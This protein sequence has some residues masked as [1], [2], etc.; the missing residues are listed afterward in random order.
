[1]GVLC[2]C[3]SIPRAEL[4]Q[5]FR[6][7]DDSRAK[8]SIRFVWQEGRSAIPFLIDCLRDKDPNVRLMALR[9]LMGIGREARSAAP[10]VLA[11]LHD[12]AKRVREHAITAAA[13]IA[14]DEPDTLR[15]LT[16]ILEQV[17]ISSES[18][19]GPWHVCLALKALGIIGHRAA[20]ASPLVYEILRTHTDGSIQEAGYWALSRFGSE[21]V[22][23][24]AV[25]LHLAEWRPKFWSLMTLRGMGG[26]AAMAA[27][28]LISVLGD[29]TLMGDVPDVLLSVAP[30]NRT[31]AKEIMSRLSR[32]DV[33]E[34]QCVR[35]YLSCICLHGLAGEEPVPVLTKLGA[36]TNTA[37]SVLAH[38]AL[39]RCGSDDPTHVQ[40]V[41]NALSSRTHP[42]ELSR[43][44]PSLLSSRESLLHE[45]VTPETYSRG[46]WWMKDL[47][48][49]D[50]E[51]V[52]RL[53][54]GLLRTGDQLVCLS[55]AVNADRPVDSLY[56]VVVQSLA[57]PFW[58]NRQDAC[59]AL[60]RYEGRDAA[61]ID[62]KVRPL[63]KDPWPRVRLAA[64]YCLYAH[65]RPV[66]LP[67][68]LRTALT[69]GIDS[70]DHLLISGIL[71]RMAPTGRDLLPDF[72]ATLNPQL[73]C[74]LQE[75]VGTLYKFAPLS[76]EVACALRLRLHDLDANA[77]ASLL[78]LVE[79]LPE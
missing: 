30:N 28:S 70:Y 8:E 44:L 24:L 60:A 18:D 12:P 23:A 49:S 64:G 68:M 4:Y 31:A 55:L 37:I 73:D 50:Q 63:L 71:T 42:A 66:N 22:T 3:V 77:N 26:Q 53:A 58:N 56:E 36:S 57:S 29:Q 78:R 39:I 21:G 13:L 46:W 51:H 34:D 67:E 16:E 72:V 61:D 15:E 32:S 17:D 14:P 74:Q 59:L 79:G 48:L 7:P 33:T 65:G 19:E 41:R 5:T 10:E 20:S 11:L 6:T 47:R 45:L 27:P 75:A 2:G 25:G 69:S 35:A 43:V 38:A 54:H 9:A 62:R 52:D 1:M 40:T 76:R